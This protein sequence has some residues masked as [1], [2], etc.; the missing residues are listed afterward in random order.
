MISPSTSKDNSFSAA[1]SRRTYEKNCCKILPFAAVL[2]FLAVIP[3]CLNYVSEF[4]F[5]QAVCIPFSLI[6]YVHFLCF[7]IL[8][9]KEIM[10]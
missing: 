3:A 10:S 4:R 6:H 5:N 1:L 2:R 7:R 9:Y 8:E